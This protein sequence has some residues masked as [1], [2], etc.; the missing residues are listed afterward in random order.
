MLL[1]DDHLVYNLTP[2]EQIFAN[3]Y[4]LRCDKVANNDGEMLLNMYVRNIQKTCCGVH[5]RII[6][7]TDINMPRMDGLELV[8]KVRQE[9]GMEIPIVIV[10]TMGGEKDRDRGM[11]LGANAYVTK[12]IDGSKLV[13][14]VKA[15][16]T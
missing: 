15:L 12:P 1:A 16:V 8:R 7:M 10:T 4:N 9:A 13:A 2:L 6:L 5:Y 11:E 14:T 3:D